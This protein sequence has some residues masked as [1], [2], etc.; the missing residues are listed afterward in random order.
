MVEMEDG[1]L[2]IH[3]LN[4]ELLAWAKEA[5]FRRYADHEL[6][7]IPLLHLSYDAA[8][9]L[10]AGVPYQRVFGEGVLK[11]VDGRNYRLLVLHATFDFWK[12]SE[13][14]VSNVAFALVDVD[15]PFDL[16]KMG[17]LIS[18]AAGM[19]RGHGEGDEVEPG[20][21]GQGP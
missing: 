8:L 3:D 10:A 18:Q 7:A 21:G 11:H 12:D 9:D 20:A 4:G 1:V 17:G 6:V 19:L 2:C 15:V 13:P 16:K 5:H 14:Q